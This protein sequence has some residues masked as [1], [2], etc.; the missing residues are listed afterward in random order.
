MTRH[1]DAR[2]PVAT[3]LADRGVSDQLRSAGLRGL[4]GRWKV[5]AHD[6][7]H[8]DLTIDDWLNDVDLRDI[9]AGAMDVAPAAERLAIEPELVGA[10]ET[11]RAATIETQRSLW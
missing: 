5:I 6:A 7:A 4:V 8:Y 2:D 9:I 3:Y 11:F 1:D 10:D